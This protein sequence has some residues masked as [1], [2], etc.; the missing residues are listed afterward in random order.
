MMGLMIALFVGCDTGFPVGGEGPP[1]GE[2]P[3]TTDTVT[4]RLINLNGAE[5]VEVEFF[6]TNAPISVLPDELFVAENRIQAS[7]GVAGTGI[8]EPFAEDM[9]QIAC[10]MSLSV[11]TFGGTF[12]DNETG[13]V[14]GMGQPRWA[15]DA[16][17][18]LCGGTV[19]FVYHKNDD[20]FLTTLLIGL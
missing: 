4:I 17:L 5:A 7:I 12:L 6:A 10:T 15:Q 20:G 19:T 18:G 16:P 3:S 11:G 2:P 14:L 9:I 1:G 8:L 13:D